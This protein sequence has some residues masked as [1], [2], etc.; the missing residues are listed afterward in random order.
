M[1]RGILLP[2]LLLI[3]LVCWSQNHWTPNP[4]QF[5][6]NM[7]CIAIIEVNGMEQTNGFLELGVFCEEECRG[8]QRLT[9]YP[10]PVDRYLLF[11]TIYGESG[12]WMSF[13]LYDHFTGNELECVCID[14]MRYVTNAINGSVSQPY[15][16]DFTGGDCIVEAVGYPANG[17]E[18][19]GSGLYPCGSMCTV[20]ATSFPGS[21]FHGWLMEGDTISLEDTLSFQVVH[22]ILLTALF[23]RTPFTV[24]ASVM[25]DMGGTVD[26][27]G[28]FYYG[29]TCYLQAI[30]AP[31]YR[32]TCWTED[33]DTLSFHP[34]LWFE[35][36]ANR[37]LVAHFESL[38][39]VG[40]TTHCM[41]LYPNPASQLVW[42]TEPLAESMLDEVEVFDMMGNRVLR[43][44]GQC[45]DVS[46]LPPAV[47][48]V[49]V[50]HGAP[51]RIVVT[52]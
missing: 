40:E 7:N 36:S 34:E 31:D 13:R 30:A 43:T 41:A 19:E 29:D 2:I 8:S 5:P 42:I 12:D 27:M 47:Y 48:L 24:E 38:E 26:G 25:P 14:S 16:F 39:A 6:S 44:Q 4:Y 33:G 46:S 20:T 32:F 50:G 9:Y 35:V 21:V 37:A 10:A 15:V 11:L 17:G 45:I 52:R 3:G 1:K 18:V 51:V 23:E 28:E 22:H 49:S